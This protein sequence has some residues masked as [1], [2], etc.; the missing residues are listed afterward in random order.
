MVH[1]RFLIIGAGPYS[2]ATAA[3][4]KSLGVEVLVVGKTLD[5]WKTNM[6]RGM[7]LRSGPDWHL[8]ARDTYTFEAYVKQ[9]GLQPA[10]TNPVPLDL[11]L[12]YASWFMGHYAVRPHPAHVTRLTRAQNSYV[13]TTDAGLEIHADHVLLGLGFAWFKHLPP[14]LV[15]K[16]PPDSY[17][18]TCDTVDFEF[19]R[20]KRVLI[21]GGRQSAFEWA[22]LI[23]EKGAEE[24]HITYRHA[25]P[26]FEESD[27]G[28]V[29]P[30]ARRTLDDPGWW[31]NLTPAAQEKIRREFWALGRLKLEPWLDAR[32]HQPAIHLHEKT[33][34][35]SAQAHDADTCDVLLDDETRLNVHHII[36]ATGYHPNMHHVAILDR[37]TIRDPL[38]T[39]EGFPALDPEFQTNLP[40]LY[41]TGFA[42][43]RD[44][45]PFFGFTVAC[46]VAAKIIGDRVA[47][48]LARNRSGL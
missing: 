10:Q 22:A 32:V 14:Q 19:Y 6:P 9:R 21:V 48:T 18:H 36:L 17:T 39:N 35:V 11:F 16:L 44:F 29:Q 47:G 28:W 31:R 40:N 26:R 13:A 27:W 38:A 43:T 7:F 42:A 4:A 8:D 15:E 34:I 45:G 46:P 5:F 24:I 1:T 33:A 20:G 2:L 30:M 12:D 3:Y 25:T 37:A 41:V 23:N